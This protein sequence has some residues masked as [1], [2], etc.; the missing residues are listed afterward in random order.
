MTNPPIDRLDRLRL[1]LNR[2]LAEDH[3]FAAATP[4]P[5]IT[6]ILDDP[7]VPLAELIRA[8][9]VGYADRPALGQRAV[10]LVMGED[11]RTTVALQ[12]RFE[13]LT[14]GEVY[15]RAQSLAAALSDGSVSVGDR[16]ATLGFT[17][18]DYAIV[19][20]ALGLAGA[21]AVPLQTSAPIDQH[22]QI[23]SEAEPVAI[24][25]AAD[26]LKEVVGMATAAPALGRV[27][28]FDYHHGVDDH[29]DALA[30]TA[31]ALSPQVH[32][33]LLQ[34]ITDQARWHSDFRAS[35]PS[36]PNA[37]RL[38]VYT[39]GST[40]TPKGA[41]Y[42]DRLSSNC[43]RGGFAP[44]WDTER[45]LP[46][47]TLNLLPLSH[48]MARII[49]Y[50]TLGAGGIAYF[51]GKSDL[52]TLFDD[53]ALV[54]PTRLELV[55]RIWETLSQAVQSEVDRRWLAGDRSAVEQ[56][57]MSRWRE[58]LLG[59]RLFSAF[60]GSAP[61]TDEFHR[62]IESFIDVDLTDGYGS[63]EGGVML[64]NGVVRRPPV[65]DYK[66][67]DVP[68]LGYFSTDLPHARGELWVK[69]INPIL[70]YYKQPEATADLFDVDGWYH[71]GDIFAE[72]SPERLMY[73][74][75]RSNV[76]KLSQ[77]EFV[78]LSH[79]EAIFGA[80]PMIRQIYLYANGSYPY[81]LAVVVPTD[82]VLANARGDLTVAKAALASI[83]RQVADDAGLQSYEIP[84]DF[85][86]ETTPFSLDNGLLTG[87]RKLA[88]PQLNQHYGPALEDCYRR[89]EE[90]RA[91]VLNDLC[92]TA[93]IRPTVYSVTKAACVLMEGD[94]PDVDGGTAFT[95]LGGDS[96]SAL[97]FANMLGKIFDVDVPVDVI[98]SP[99]NDLAAVAAHIDTLLAQGRK[100]PTYDTIH[101]R[102][103]TEVRAA[104]LTLDAFLDDATLAAAPTLPPAR[105]DVH[106]VLVTGATGF[107]GRYL[108]LHW[109][110]QMEATGGKVTCIIRAASNAHARARLDAIFDSGDPNLLKL[111]Q[112][113]AP[114]LE[115]LAGDKG[116]HHLGL[117]DA[118]WRRL[119]HS[120]D[121]IVDPA[122]MVNHLL[123]YRQLFGSNVIG[124]AELIRLAMTTRLKAFAYVSTIAVGTGIE[125]ELF[126][127]GADIRRISPVR[128]LDEGYANGYSNSKWAGE[129][130]LREAHDLCGLPVSVFRCD[131]ILAETNFS[132]QLNV[133]DQFTRMILSLVATG[134][135][136]YSFYEL[137][138]AGHRQRAHYDALPVGFIAESISTLV[139]K[140]MTGYTTYHVMNPHD[141][142]IGMDTYV[143]WLIEAGCAL[144]RVNGYSQWLSQF[145]HAL[146]ELPERQRQASILPLLDSY[147]QPLRPLN[148]SLAPVDEFR[149]AVQAAGIGVDSDIPHVTSAMILKY[150]SDLRRL[151]F[152]PADVEATE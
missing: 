80:H 83:V 109:L 97:T 19:D 130:L 13:L 151:G 98:I 94:L 81:P 52:S 144:K 22:R 62:W 65:L 93:A 66:L 120:V 70:G 92:R 58:N 100:Q 56:E 57:V 89:L 72:I 39:S 75:R 9:M 21:V 140:A 16:V 82:E 88:R 74:D 26:Y 43:W 32:V 44:A 87:I 152:L 24:I 128:A 138:S 46:S 33:E 1:R 85:I 49:L 14:Y 113:L 61:I 68:E 25:A 105:R 117:D 141:D 5:R 111:Y 134:I 149:S 126:V 116:E 78:T 99:A 3:Q 31:T 124:T 110:R 7:A 41:M 18:A 139:A 51:A 28:V 118:T 96:L 103:T 53:L 86:V 107:L 17:S 121:L 11:G 131:M 148:T 55:P 35:E 108:T 40:G 137:D 114:H 95:D 6:A 84:R 54:R 112:Q 73:L 102:D 63:T 8:V 122:A 30:F 60:C 15:Q 37:L 132:G 50:T 77:G 29:R 145:R 64:A 38:L 106:S 104:D 136:P 147:Q 23:L 67:V 20:I 101:G 59:G 91:D 125:P 133:P 47:I 42:T 71:T 48:A 129:V 10:E 12:P 69:T 143:D 135:A 142:G 115:V 76:V 2:L 146:Q 27:V 45:Q 34:E 123:P 4:D 79:V 36:A 119:S 90:R 127:E 150:V